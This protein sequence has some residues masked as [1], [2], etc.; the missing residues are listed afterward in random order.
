MAERTMNT[1]GQQIVHAETEE[2]RQ[3]KHVGKL[4]RKEV[5]RTGQAVHDYYKIVDYNTSR[6][7]FIGEEWVED[8]A[9]DFDNDALFR[10]TVTA[11]A[12]AGFFLVLGM[13]A[14]VT[15]HLVL[16]RSLNIGLALAFVGLLAFIALSGVVFINLNAMGR[17]NSDD[18]HKVSDAISFAKV[19]PLYESSRVGTL[20][21]Y[22]GAG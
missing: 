13:G 17:V 1:F 12:A 19:E 20:Q 2:D 3:V 7:E 16:L 15:S 18:I 8:V 21:R 4:V 11:A 10:R 5:S 22:V 9:R 14:L 6:M